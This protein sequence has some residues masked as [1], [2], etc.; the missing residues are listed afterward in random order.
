MRAWVLG[1]VWPRLPICPCVL[2]GVTARADLEGMVPRGSVVTEALPGHPP[3][4]PHLQPD[5]LW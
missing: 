3:G 1:S 5:T 2:T 4:F